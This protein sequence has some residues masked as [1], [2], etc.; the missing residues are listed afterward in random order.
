MQNIESNDKKENKPERTKGEIEMKCINS[1]CTIFTRTKYC[2][3]ANCY[4]FLPDSRVL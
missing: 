3:V 2:T 4:D 1:I